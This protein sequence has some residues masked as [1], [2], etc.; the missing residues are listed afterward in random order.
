MSKYKKGDK[1]VIEIEEVVEGGFS[2]MN[3][4]KDFYRIKGFKS[5]IFDDWGLGKLKNAIYTK[6]DDEKAIKESYKKGLKD[7]F[8]AVK[9]IEFEVKEGGINFSNLIK[10]FGYSGL[11][12]I[13]VNFEPKEI[14]EKIKRFK[15]C[16]GKFSVGDVV[17]H[18][19]NEKFILVVTEVFSDGRFCG[20]KISETDQYGELF[21]YY[22][23]R[24]A[25]YFEKTG[26]YFNLEEIFNLN[27]GE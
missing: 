20:I 1:F 27:K 26:E 22:D 2:E 23:K 11:K 21:G 12:S 17:K 4:P 10:I 13:I 18:K 19:N 6:K 8:Y 7:A 25:E 15:E 5:I 24:S 9:M 16:Q 14:V 3:E